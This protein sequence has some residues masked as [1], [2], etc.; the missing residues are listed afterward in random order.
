MN[1][2]PT[3]ITPQLSPLLW[4]KVIGVCSAVLKNAGV[5]T[6]I[7]MHGWTESAFEDHPEFETL[8]WEDVPVLLAKLPALLEQRQKLGFTLGKDDW[9]LMGQT[10]VPFELLCCHENDLHLKTTDLNLAAQFK[11]ALAVLGVFLNAVTAT[12]TPPSTIDA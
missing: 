7:T 5:T 4:R 12:S 10:N 1:P 9:W 2:D 3:W 8:Q 6:L 11:T